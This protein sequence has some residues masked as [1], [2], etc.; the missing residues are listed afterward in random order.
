MIEHFIGNEEALSLNL[1][2]GFGTR[3]AD[4]QEGGHRGLPEAWQLKR[5]A[6]VGRI[7]E[8][9]KLASA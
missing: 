4:S 1:S 9:A 2:G 6:P 7:V 5:R 8:L 3:L